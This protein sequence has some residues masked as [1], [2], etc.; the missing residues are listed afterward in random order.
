M[1]KVAAVVEVKVHGVSVM[2]WGTS[3]R[4]T[5][6][7]TCRFDPDKVKG[8]GLKPLTCFVMS[9]ED[10]LLK[11]GAIGFEQQECV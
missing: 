10:V 5:W 3:E 7:L 9:L 6:S 8:E 4:I 11:L 1:V 2:L